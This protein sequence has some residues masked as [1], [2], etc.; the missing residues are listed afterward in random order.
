MLA[1]TLLDNVSDMLKTRRQLLQ[2]VVAESNV[3]CDVALVSR[4]VERLLE[5]VLGVIKLLLLEEHAALR[6]DRLSRV[7]RHLTDIG[8][9]LLDL[10]ELVLDGALQ[11]QDAVGEVGRLNLLQHLEYILIHGR[12]EQR[13]RMIQ[14]VKV[15]AIDV[16]EELG[17]LIIAVGCIT[18]VLDLEVGIAK[19]GESGTVPGLELQLVRE[20]GDDLGILLVAEQR[21]DRLRV[22]AVW[23]GSE[24]VVHIKIVWL[25]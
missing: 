9:C 18:V 5:L 23:H 16:R 2:L 1:N 24:L 13:L 10:L 7:G 19:K 4:Q 3:V 22:L 6:H 25:Q 8:L 21:V 20:D 11:L 14:L 12:L 17:Q 15:V